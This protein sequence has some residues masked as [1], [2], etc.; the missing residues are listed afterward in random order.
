MLDFML[1]Y[2][3]PDHKRYGKFKLSHFEIGILLKCQSA[4]DK[5]GN[6]Y[7]R[8]LTTCIRD[9]LVPG[10]DYIVKPKIKNQ[11]GQR[12][13]FLTE[14]ALFILALLLRGDKRYRVDMTYNERLQR[15]QSNYLSRCFA[16]PT[17]AIQEDSFKP[18][19]L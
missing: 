16:Q 3:K 1:L 14:E 11:Q 15:D 12:I 18:S 8:H 19:Y 10:R 2:D 9:N 17:R 13:W 5:Y 7:Y 4:T 6:M